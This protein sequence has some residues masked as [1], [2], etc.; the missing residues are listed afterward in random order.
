MQVDAINEG[1]KELVP[2]C[3]YIQKL[4]DKELKLESNQKEGSSIKYFAA[5]IREIFSI[6]FSVYKNKRTEMVPIRVGIP[7]KHPYFIN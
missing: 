6:I 1:Y 4:L 7:I 2:V 5:L 3:E